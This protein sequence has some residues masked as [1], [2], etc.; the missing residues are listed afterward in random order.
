[1]ATLEA[2]NKFGE[3]E[4]IS[5]GF[6]LGIRQHDDVM[7]AYK[8][9]RSTR[10]EQTLE[11]G[12][13]MVLRLDINEV[14]LHHAEA[15]EVSSSAGSIRVT[16]Y[17]ATGNENLFPATPTQMP[18]YNQNG[19]EK[20]I[21]GVNVMAEFNYYPAQTTNPFDGLDDIENKPI[22]AAITGGPVKATPTTFQGV[23]GR[24]Y[25][26]NKTFA[27]VIENI[28]AETSD[29]YYG[30]TFHEIPIDGIY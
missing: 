18:I 4:Q 2:K 22:R 5:Q 26:S 19:L 25:P 15:R 28:G 6:G 21:S 13:F 10:V 27:L 7:L 9:S 23:S 1:M 12:Q 3:L 8:Y 16:L 20:E 30:Y 29:V 11:T 14:L 17:D 24:A